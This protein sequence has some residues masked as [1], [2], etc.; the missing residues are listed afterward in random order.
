MKDKNNWDVITAGNEDVLNKI[1]KRLED[2]PNFC[3]CGVKISPFEFQCLNCYWKGMD[4]EKE[5][6]K[7]TEAW[8]KHYAGE[9]PS[10]K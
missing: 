10:P 9:G 7:R 2:N 6:N 3:Y 4:R 5:Q 1:R 8:V